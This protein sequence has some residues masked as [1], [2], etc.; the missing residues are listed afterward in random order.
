M[1]LFATS[2][3]YKII[4]SSQT[5][6]SFLLLFGFTT[7]I[8]NQTYNVIKGFVNWLYSK[9][10]SFCLDGRQTHLVKIV[11]CPRDAHDLNVTAT[12]QRLGRYVVCFELFVVPKQHALSVLKTTTTYTNMRCQENPAMQKKT[13]SRTSIVDH[14]WRP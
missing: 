2:I 7:R 1:Y 10:N 4:L 12:F 3:A 9:E 8:K 13:Y 14:T 5:T 11:Y 6:M